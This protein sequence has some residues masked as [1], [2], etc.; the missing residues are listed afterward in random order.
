MNFART[1]S[2]TVL[3]LLA[4]LGGWL[5]GKSKP[6]SLVN[7]TSL[8]IQMRGGFAYVNTPP[9]NMVEVAY[10]KSYTLEE[11]NVPQIGTSLDVLRGTIVEPAS[12]PTTNRT[13]DVGGAVITLDAPLGTAGPISTR[14]GHP[15][16]PD[17]PADTNLDTDWADLGWVPYVSPDFPTNG[18]N[19]NWRTMVDGRLVLT[20]GRMTGAA[21]SRV[22]Y[23]DRKFEFKNGSGGTSYKQSVTDTAKYNAMMLGDRI[24]LNLTGARSGITRIAV[25]PDAAGQPVVL[26]LDGKHDMSAPPLQDGD[27]VTHF[28]AFYQLMQPVP[29][30]SSWYLPYLLSAA[31]GSGSAGS[32]GSGSPGYY[33]PGD[34]F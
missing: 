23:R 15:V 4:L 24:V 7:V 33:C 30:S 9:Q 2:I 31:G 6:G 1:V 11:C 12:N 26:R 34:S 28:C 27:P 22:T 16:S 21:P 13:F 5:L 25:R 18:L 8:E 32:G 10:L 3:V 19:P 17:Q 29:P 14:P 20:G